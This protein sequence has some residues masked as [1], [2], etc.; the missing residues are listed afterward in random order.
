MIIKI[1]VHPKSKKIEIKKSELNEVDGVWEIWIKSPPEKNKA[2]EEVIQIVSNELK[3]P[4]SKITLVTGSKSRIKR[5]RV[6][7]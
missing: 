1:K 3:V 6:D 4:K 2:N 7:I 5:F